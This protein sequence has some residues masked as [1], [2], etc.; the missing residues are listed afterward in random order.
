MLTPGVLVSDTAIVEE[1]VGVMAELAWDPTLPAGVVVEAETS[2]DG[3]SVTVLVVIDWG[4]E[5]MEGEAGAAPVGTVVAGGGVVVRGSWTAGGGAVGFKGL[6]GSIT[7]GRDARPTPTSALASSGSMLAPCSTFI[8]TLK[9]DTLGRA[10]SYKKTVVKA[11]NRAMTRVAA[12]LTSFIIITP[13]KNLVPTHHVPLLLGRSGFWQKFIC[14]FV[15]GVI[16]M[17]PPLDPI[18]I[19]N[20]ATNHTWKGC[21]G[22]SVLSL[23]ED[24]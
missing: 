13:G 8:C 23:S 1:P 18:S 19:Q 20:F 7:D 24:N 17:G 15:P 11:T 21:A 2:A 10:A 12:V 16:D 22:Q 3:L 9:P 6:A 14:T 5:A 4:S